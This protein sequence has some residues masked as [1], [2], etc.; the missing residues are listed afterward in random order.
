M[1]KQCNS[2]GQLKKQCNSHLADT[3]NYLK[4]TVWTRW[5]YCMKCL[6]YSTRLGYL[7]DCLSVRVQQVVKVIW[8]KAHRRRRRMVQRCWAGDGNVFSHEGTLAP[9]GEY[10]C[11][12][13]IL[14]PSRVHKRNGKWI[15]SGIFAQLTA[16]S[17]YTLQW[18]PLS[19][20]ISTSHV[21]H[22]D[23]GPC[24]PTTQ[25]AP[26][27]FSRVFTDDRWVSLYF[28]MV[29]L[30]FPLEIAPSHVG[31]WTSCNT[32]FTGPTGVR[33][34]NGNLIVLAV[35]AGLT[36][37]TDWQSDRQTDRPRYSVRCSVIMRNYEGHGKGTQSLHV[38]MNNIATTKL[39]SVCLKQSIKY[40]V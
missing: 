13:C 34:A 31:I 37:V 29:C 14:R 5:L 8:H 19:T 22:D 27:P 25:T 11:N 33:D 23:L 35:F 3:P 6:Q 20:R 4:K 12:L 28:I 9:P 30:C 21:T 10:D 32:W 2:H 39:L 1:H 24:E 17:A 26:R 7:C 15:G 36:S 18:A 38:S 16:E 40:L